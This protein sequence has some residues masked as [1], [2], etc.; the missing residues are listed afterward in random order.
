[1]RNADKIILTGTILDFY[2][3]V[4]VDFALEDKIFT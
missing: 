2:A 3:V 4:D 1:M